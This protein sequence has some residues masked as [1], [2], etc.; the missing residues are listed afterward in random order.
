MVT[1]MNIDQLE[2]RFKSSGWAPKMTEIQE[3][4]KESRKLPVSAMYLKGP[5][6]TGKSTTLPMY[7]LSMIKTWPELVDSCV[8]YLVGNPIEARILREYLEETFGRWYSNAI[9]NNI[10]IITDYAEGIGII[11]KINVDQTH[12]DMIILMD[13]EINP[14]TFGE[15]IFARVMQWTSECRH[16]DS[17]CHLATIAAASFHCGRTIE[18]LQ[19]W[20]GTAP[21]VIEIPPQRRSVRSQRWRDGWSL[22]NFLNSIRPDLVDFTSGSGLVTDEAVQSQCIVSN[23]DAFNYKKNPTHTRGCSE[24]IFKSIASSK[25]IL[26]KPS[27]SFSTRSERLRYFVSAGVEDT[28]LFDLHTSH[29]LHTTRQLSRAEIERERSWLLK[30]VVPLEESVFFQKFSTDEEQAR[31]ETI[32]FDC[33]AYNEQLTWTVLS[34][35]QHWP[36]TP[37]WHM[38]I[39]APVDDRAII[40]TCRRL[41]TIGCVERLDGPAGRYRVTRRGTRLLNLWVKDAKNMGDFQVA[42]LLATVMEK[43][44][45]YSTN[46]RRVLVRIAAIATT[47][48]RNFVSRKD[49]EGT[50]KW[51]G[52]DEEDAQIR[53]ACAGIGAERIEN[54]AVWTALALWQ[55]WKANGRP[56]RGLQVPSCLSCNWEQAKPILELVHAFEDEVGIS[57]C[58]DELRDT[59][60]TDDEVSA[61]EI[62][63]MW[64]WLHQIAFFDPAPRPGVSSNT[65]ITDVIC[66]RSF[67]AGPGNM[68]NIEV[69]FGGKDKVEHECVGFFAV[70]FGLEKSKLDVYTASDLT[71]IPIRHF[72]DVYKQTG[73]KY[74]EAVVTTYPIFSR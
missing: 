3:F 53:S 35:L 19:K 13:L 21:P 63:L 39:R 47:P 22:N 28:L 57:H 40:E 12:R 55:N 32:H 41:V 18:A 20:T 33:R 59:D 36:G 54:G 31:P 68:I 43:T 7:L 64:A 44:H 9:E 11:D 71:V 14:S 30:S 72:S 24:S 46:L 4:I 49:Q 25:V 51:R 67:T 74:P 6:D 29:V 38:P 42:Y 27:L 48:L 66:G 2:D 1:A 58:S 65:I 50:W 26:I 5:H 61:V 45:Q 73:I 15:L 16:T 8:M 62:E 17:A 60:L 56:E 23:A 34:I 52:R 70:Y 10:L 37:I 69:N